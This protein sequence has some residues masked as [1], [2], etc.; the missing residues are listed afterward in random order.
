IGRVRED[1][2]PADLGDDLLEQR[3]LFANYFWADAEGQPRDV[4]A[5]AREARDE[6]EANRIGATGN[7]DDGDRRGSVLGCRHSLR[8]H[9]YDDVDLEPDQLAREVGQPVG[10]ALRESIID[11]NIL[12]LDPPELAQSLPER[13]E[14]GRR[15]T[16]SR[17]RKNTYPRHLC[18]L[19]RAGGERRGK[20]ARKQDE[21]GDE[22]ID[23]Q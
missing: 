10:P 19:L 17:R 14:Y 9:R 7:H 21:Q 2:N 23:A 11:D 1:R 5:R 12:T 18:R 16:G 4:P 13:V 6:P 15:H 8:P 3:E 22:W 20:E